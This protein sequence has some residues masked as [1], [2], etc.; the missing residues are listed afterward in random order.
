MGEVLLLPNT[1]MFLKSLGIK[2][3]FMS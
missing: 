1:I 2:Y 3:Y